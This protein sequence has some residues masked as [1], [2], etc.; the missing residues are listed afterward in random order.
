MATG[1]RFNLAGQVKLDAAGGG[2]VTLSPPGTIPGWIVNLTSINVTTRNA[3]PTFKLYRGNVMPLNFLEGSYSGSQDSSNSVLRVA[4]GEA[5]V[6]VWEGG[7][8]GA[9]ASLHC[10]GEVA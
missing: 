8:P 7:D 10:S 5:L 6:G 9:T 4:P 1:D 2:Q 3:E